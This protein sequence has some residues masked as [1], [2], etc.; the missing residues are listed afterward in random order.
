M[1]TA[2]SIEFQFGSTSEN[3]REPKI[4]VMKKWINW[5]FLTIAITLLGV[6]LQNS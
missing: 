6:S 2:F 1:H 3:L 4:L 5:I